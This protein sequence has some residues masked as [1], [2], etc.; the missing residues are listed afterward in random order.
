MKKIE[1]LFD[2]SLKPPS[3]LAWLQEWRAVLELG[4]G[5]AAAPALA[6]LPRG[7]G[8]PVMVLPGFLTSDLSTALLRQLLGVWGYRVEKWNLGPNLTVNQ[9]MVDRIGDRAHAVRHEQGRKVSLI[10][11]SLGGL[12]AREVAR[13]NADDVRQLVTLSSPFARNFK[14]SNL[15]GV[16]E[17]INGETISGMGVDLI[18]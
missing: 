7:D 18:R 4:V 2:E 14:A 5:L 3:H 9:A 12:L 11:W 17:F 13:R 1:P 8:H 16:Y 15:G 6:R 10:G